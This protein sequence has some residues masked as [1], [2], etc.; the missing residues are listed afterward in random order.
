MMGQGDTGR[1]G[2]VVQS[3][4]VVYGTIEKYTSFGGT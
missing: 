3:L 1:L 2:L 4:Y